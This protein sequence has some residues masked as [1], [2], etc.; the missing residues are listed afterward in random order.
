[1]LLM[2]PRLSLAALALA[3]AACS[4]G[5]KHEE[6]T[7]TVSAPAPDAPRPATRIAC[8]SDN[9]GITLPSGFCA[10][11]FADSIDG[12]RHIAVA[13]NGD[14]FVQRQAQRGEGIV[15]L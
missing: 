2:R 10:S 8:A 5:T 11:I 14:V 12:A 15:A 9:G 7:G 6:S 13:P 3:A 4:D 1:M